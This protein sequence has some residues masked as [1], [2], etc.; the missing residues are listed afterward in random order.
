MLYNNFFSFFFLSDLTSDGPE[1]KCWLAG[2]V[3]DR[4]LCAPCICCWYSCGTQVGRNHAAFQSNH[5]IVVRG[6]FR[7]PA[8]CI[9]VIIKIK[10]K[11][12]E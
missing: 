1:A 7:S 4:T 2:L 12:Y 6:R 5:F 8:Y 3:F 9:L 10:F 11:P